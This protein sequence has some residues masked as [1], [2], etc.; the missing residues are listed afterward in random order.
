MLRGLLLFALFV[1]VSCCDSSSSTQGMT[2]AVAPGAGNTGA[3]PPPNLPGVEWTLET[4]RGTDGVYLPLPINATWT[5]TFDVGGGVSGAA[6]CNQGNGSWQAGD[7]TLTIIEWAEDGA[8]CE[9]REIIPTSTEN[10]TSRLFAGETVVAQIEQGRLFLDTGNGA[11]L[12][13]SGRA[14]NEDEQVVSVETLVRTT[15]GSRAG[16]G[17]PVFGDLS[18]PYVIYR[19]AES[20]EADYILLPAETAQWPTLPPA[21]DFER[22]I[23][24]GAYLSF[25]PSQSSDVVV[26]GAHVSSSGLEIDVV[27]ID[28]NIRDD[29]ASGNCGSNA[30]LSAPYTLVRVDSVVEPVS[31]LEVVRPGC[32]GLPVGGN[33]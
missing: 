21:V 25:N 5:L 27:R 23:V 6:L 14:R 28:Q 3:L 11:Q 31:F 19:D 12:V 26:R 10:I 18:T 7:G 20:L 13:F 24:V 15:G 4:V 8:F 9:S 16:N 1:A 29:E 32:S 33:L 22:S 17:D 30:A 2:D